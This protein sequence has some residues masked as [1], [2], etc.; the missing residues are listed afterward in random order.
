MDNEELVNL[1][2]AVPAGWAL[3]EVQAPTANIAVN[4]KDPPRIELRTT[5]SS[6]L[7]YKALVASS[8]AAFL[9]GA[10]MAASVARV[11]A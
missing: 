4:T 9:A 11:R 2:R 1:D 3:P 7:S 5:A 10:I 6:Y 8:V